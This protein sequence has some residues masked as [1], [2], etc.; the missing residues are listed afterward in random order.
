[1]ASK[2][3]LQR[4]FFSN[5]HAT[6]SGFFTQAS[7]FVTRGEFEPITPSV[8]HVNL[9]GCEPFVFWALVVKKLPDKPLE[10]ISDQNF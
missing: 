10:R 4:Y 2:T 1:M 7:H 8:V 3:T 5:V 9:F 6:K